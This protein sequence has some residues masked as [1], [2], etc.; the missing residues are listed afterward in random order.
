[1]VNLSLVR[2]LIQKKTVSLV[3]AFQDLLCQVTWSKHDKVN[4][5]AYF[6][7]NQHNHL[8]FTIMYTDL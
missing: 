4:K 3:M 8:K 1:M 6:T 2:K 7:S 5:I